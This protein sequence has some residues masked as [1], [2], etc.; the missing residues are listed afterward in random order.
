M[1]CLADDFVVWKDFPKGLRV[2]LLDKDAPSAEQTKLKLEAMDYVVSLF[3]NENDALDAISRK[4][5]SFHVAIV[6][7]TSENNNDSSFRFLEMARD[8]P[9]IVVSNVRCLSTM[10]KCIA[11]GAAE[12]LEK[13]LSDDKIRNLWQHVVHKAFNGGGGVLSKSLKPIKETVVSMLHLESETTDVKNEVP[14]EVDN[15]EKEQQL[16]GFDDMEAS[17][18]FPAPSTPQL[19]QGA[20]LTDDGDFQDKPNCLSEKRSK[21]DMNNLLGKSTCSESKSVDIASNNI[22]GA[23]SAKEVSVS[24][25]EDENAEKANSSGEDS[26]KRK[27]CD[28]NNPNSHS[29]KSN[30]KKMKVDW[31]PELHKQFVQAVEQLGIDQAIPSKILELMKVDGLTR[32]NVASHLQK[33]RMHKRHILPKDDDRRWQHHADPTRRGY[34]PRSLVPIPPYH[35][36][37]GYPTG[38][39]Y[40]AWGHPGYH[41][42]GVQMWNPAAIQP[43]PRPPES[44]TWKHHS[45]I[46]ADAWGCPVVPPYGQYSLPSQYTPLNKSLD[47]T[48]DQNKEPR[49]FAGFHLAEEV[50]DRAVKEAMNKPWLPLP[51]GL[52]A[53][54]TESVLAEL[55]RQ[56]IPSIPPLRR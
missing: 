1:V 46:H 27:S 17:D 48:W 20:R 13:P 11:L 8:L 7:V 50:I 5:E 9:T 54:C 10:M 15:S 24:A 45:G 2:L 36:N 21:D 56:G 14:S 12:F 28:Y 49:A 31:T 35:Y 4:V 32:H 37:Y 18:K 51:L 42:S 39:A 16:S 38:Q 30:K 23:V 33:Y 25:A 52:K 29:N 53:P 41:P 43:W 34:V 40:P 47:L 6:E 26:K 22:N 55:H 44:W 19:E 3:F